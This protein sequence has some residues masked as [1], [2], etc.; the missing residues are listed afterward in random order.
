MPR[1][2]L[3]AVLVLFSLPLAAAEAD[4]ERRLL[5][6]ERDLARLEA[7]LAAPPDARLG[8]YLEVD[9]GVLLDLQA[10]TLELDGHPVAAALY[11]ANENDALE[12]GGVDRLY[13]GAVAPGEH[14]LTVIVTG[15]GPHRRPYRLGHA[16]P[17]RKT[18]GPLNLL[19][20]LVDDGKRLQPR[21]EVRPW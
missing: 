14:R 12:R 17:F 8:V 19:V 9:T 16:Y 3:A 21:V 13:L 6:L 1:R 4:L 15:I 7:D 2:C 11:R 18:P 10:V 5:Q 20:R